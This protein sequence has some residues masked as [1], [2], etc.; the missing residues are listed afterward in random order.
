MNLIPPKLAMISNL[1][2]Y[3]RCSLAVA[4]PVVSAMKVQACPVPTALYS[5]H[6]AF[7]TWFCKDLT[8]DTE[9]YLK[10]FSDLQL[11]FD[12]IYFGFV[13]SPAQIA[14]AE[15]FFQSQPQAKIILDPAMGDHGKM[16]SSLTPAHCEGIKGL[17]KYAH[18]FT[19]NLTEACLLT[20]T[21]FPGEDWDEKELLQFSGKNKFSGA[22]INFLRELSEK[23][24]ALGAEQIVITGIRAGD[25][26]INYVSDAAGAKILPSP[27][28]GKPYHGTGDLF[29]AVLCGDALHGVPLTDSVK[30]A[31]A[32]VGACIEVSER[33]G[34]PEREGV[35]FENCLSLLTQN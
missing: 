8:D 29:A 16:Y 6:L 18:I 22:R 31:S 21:P 19:P 20:D 3:G 26:Y 27:I 33:A 30:K 11:S 10:G 32:F 25:C 15:R 5:N 1:T 12:G 35:L 4:I 2:G 23:L 24:H 14:A 17:I 34:V 28:K 9:G 7:P 13:G